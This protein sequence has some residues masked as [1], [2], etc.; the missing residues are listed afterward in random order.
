MVGG[1]RTSIIGTTLLD[2]LKAQFIIFLHA[3]QL[4]LHLKDLEIQLLDKTA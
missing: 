2:F 3:A 4:V 1:A